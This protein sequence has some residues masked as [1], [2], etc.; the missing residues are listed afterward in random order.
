MDMIHQN[1]NKNASNE[2]AYFDLNLKNACT[3]LL[4]DP[5]NSRQCKFNIVSAGC[6]AT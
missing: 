5:E 6:T 2:D 1:I 3:Q 4:L